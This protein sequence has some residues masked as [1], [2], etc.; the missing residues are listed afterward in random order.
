MIKAKTSSDKTVWANYRDTFDVEIRYAPRAKMRALINECQIREWDQKTHQP[1]ERADDDKFFK[2]IAEEI[3]VN[4]RG[5]SGEVLRGMID[6]DQYPQ[7][8]ID[9]PYSKES[10]FELL[11][12]AYGFDRWVQHIATELEAFEA[13]RR[14]AETK[15]S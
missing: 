4:W 3:V 11:K 15:N 10:C 8:E 7:D 12:G 5:L 14:A 2:R 13:A 1:I 9:E 6:L